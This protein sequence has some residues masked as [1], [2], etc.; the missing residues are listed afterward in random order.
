MT[1]DTQPEDPAGELDLSA[2][3]P[4]DPPA[5]FADGVVARARVADH[6]PLAAARGVPLVAVA[7]LVVAVLALVGEV[8]LHGTRLFV[9]DD[10]ARADIARLESA[11]QL[12]DAE[13]RELQERPIAA[14]P[15]TVPTPALEPAPA[16]PPAAP[17]PPVPAVAPVAPGDAGAVTVRMRQGEATVYIDGRVVGSTPWS[18]R[19]PV[20]LHKVTYGIGNDKYSFRIHVKTDETVTLDK[21]FG[22]P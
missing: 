16:E 4:P 21:D 8:A 17:P 15:V 2:W 7:A 10:D 11:V 13:V 5:A 19:V 14:Q 1:D 3:Q 18:G 20:G 22:P 9:G 12:L 6:L